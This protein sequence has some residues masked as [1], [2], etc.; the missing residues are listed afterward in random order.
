MVMV[1]VVV[2]VLSAREILDI[3]AIVEDIAVRLWI[4]VFLYEGV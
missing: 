4:S 1:G 2:E 3:V